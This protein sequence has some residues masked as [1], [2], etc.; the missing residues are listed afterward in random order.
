MVGGQ[1]GRVGT[2]LAPVPSKLASTAA[3]ATCF[4]W[5][6]GS[7]SGI[8]GGGDGI[9]GIQFIQ[10]LLTATLGWGKHIGTQLSTLDAICPVVS[11]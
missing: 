4:C 10:N 1:L 6:F 7:G 2:I 8:I 5:W 9:I 11:A 3:T